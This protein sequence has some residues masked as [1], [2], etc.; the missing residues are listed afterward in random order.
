MKVIR[1]IPVPPGGPLRDKYRGLQEHFQPGLV[2]KN[3]DQ[4]GKP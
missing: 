2:K 4:V 1:V 3:V